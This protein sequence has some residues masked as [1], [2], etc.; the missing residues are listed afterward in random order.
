MVIRLTAIKANSK[1]T[2]KSHLP[3][4]SHEPNGEEIEIGDTVTFR[5]VRV[6]KQGEDGE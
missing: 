1:G 4:S 2:L 6:E 3:V 5:V